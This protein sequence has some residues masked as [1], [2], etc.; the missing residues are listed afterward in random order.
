M[1]DSIQHVCLR[2]DQ[3]P[4]HQFHHL[5]NWSYQLLIHQGHP[6]HQTVQPIYQSLVIVVGCQK[7]IERNFTE[8]TLLEY[9]N[10]QS[11]SSSLRLYQQPRGSFYQLTNCRQ[12]VLRVIQ[13]HLSHLVDLTILNQKE[14]WFAMAAMVHRVGGHTLVLLLASTCVIFPTLMIAL[15]EG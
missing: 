10:H 1:L 9:R 6:P 8:K 7:V 2:L 14:R 13:L 5:S 15:E 4:I 3:D 12:E 11:H